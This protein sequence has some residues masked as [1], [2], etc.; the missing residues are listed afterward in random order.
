MVSIQKGKFGA[1]ERLSDKNG[2]IAALAIDQ[3][4]SLRKMIGAAK[5]SGAT[6]EELTDFKTLISK[7]LTPYASS[8]LLDPE[9]GLPAGR[10]R[11]RHCGLIT[12]YEKTGYDAHTPGRLP[13]LLAN[14]SVK[15]IKEEDSDAAKI[16]VYYDKDDSKQIN[17][18][19]KA[20]VERVGSECRA[21]DIPFFL[22]LVTY[23]EKVSAP[24][25]YARIKPQ[26][27]IEAVKVFSEERYGVD[28]LKLQVPVDMS[29][30][31]GIGENE[32]VYSDEQAGEYFRQVD[33]AA[34]VPYI[35]LSAGVSAELFQRT[36]RFAR[37]AGSRFNGVLCG[38]AT[39]REGVKAY[40]EGGE[41]K[42]AE[43][44]RTQGRK[45]IEALNAVLAESATPWYETYGGKDRITVE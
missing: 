20:F 19:K 12:S 28:V 27:V 11:D 22:E 1:L 21:E 31:E 33:E 29:R 10:N 34:K 15:R 36:L 35:W 45:N 7:E 4:G 25:D 16:L 32:A 5:G 38:R 23:D 41:E 44:L 24:A 6:T 39:W 9:F 37:E 43:W 14:W 3:R 17:D 40:G 26:K 13:D 8:I 18:V 30:V 42:A 2:I